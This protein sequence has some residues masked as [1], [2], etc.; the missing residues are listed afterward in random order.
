V[1]AP[2]GC[3]SAVSCIDSQF[4]DTQLDRLFELATA[5]DLQLEA[6][7]LSIVVLQAA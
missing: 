4:I 1:V 5:T 7:G 2:D 3:D 6:W